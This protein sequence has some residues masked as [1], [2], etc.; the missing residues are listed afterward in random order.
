MSRRAAAAL[1]APLLALAGFALLAAADLLGEG[2]W[3]MRVL[4][5]AVEPVILLL[6][7]LCGWWVTRQRHLLPALIALGLIVGWGLSAV[8]FAQ[9]GAAAPP[10]LV[11]SR[12]LA[13]L[14]VGYLSNL[15]RLLLRPPSARI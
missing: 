3:T 4:A 10:A 13:C 15:L 6:A 8:D 14:A 12:L 7:G 2:G 1:R 11:A 9:P 5:A